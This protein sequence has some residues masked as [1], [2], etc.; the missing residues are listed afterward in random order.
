VIV[1]TIVANLLV[2]IHCNASIVTRTQLP[3]AYLTAATHGMTEDAERLKEL[4]VAKVSWYT[5][6]S[7]S[8]IT[9]TYDACYE[10]T[11]ATYI[12]NCLTVVVLLN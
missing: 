2:C 3:L 10:H 11:A 1:L 8:S 5:N 9:A 12:V 7:S 6:T 4:L